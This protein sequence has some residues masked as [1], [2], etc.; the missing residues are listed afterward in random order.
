MRHRIAMPIAR[1]TLSHAR[2]R[3]VVAP[4]LPKGGRI[5]RSRGVG[6]PSR[7]PDSSPC[8]TVSRS[9]ARH[10]TCVRTRPM[11]AI[12]PS[13][14]FVL[15]TGCVVGTNTGGTPGGDDGAGDDGTPTPDAPG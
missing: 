14:V 13:L 8:N 2:R 6:A 9:H 3:D 5:L 1:Y 10:V 15:V 11:R 4:T 12:L 7:T